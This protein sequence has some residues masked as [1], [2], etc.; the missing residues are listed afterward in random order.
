MVAGQTDELHVALVV[1][2]VSLS[3]FW[4]HEG[5]AQCFPAPVKTMVEGQTNE[6][7][8]HIALEDALHKDLYPYQGV[9][10]AAVPSLLKYMAPIPRSM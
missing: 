1:Q 5:P 8:L 2:H 10:L 6:L 3:T 9:A 4:S 7:L